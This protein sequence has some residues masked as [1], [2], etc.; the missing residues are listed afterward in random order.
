MG[1]KLKVLLL[2]TWNIKLLTSVDQG[3]RKKLTDQN[4]NICPYKKPKKKE[5]M[6]FPIPYK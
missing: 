6:F 5:K 3:V 4:V 1:M 2:V